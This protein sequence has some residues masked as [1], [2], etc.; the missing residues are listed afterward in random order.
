MATHDGVPTRTA[1]PLPGQPSTMTSFLPPPYPLR[2]LQPPLPSCHRRSTS[3]FP[4]L[5]PASSFPSMRAHLPRLSVPLSLDF[6]LYLSSPTPPPSLFPQTLRYPFIRL[7]PS[8]F[9]FLRLSSRARHSLEYMP[10]LPPLLNLNVGLW[11]YAG[12]IL[13]PATYTST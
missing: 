3:T 10:S 4:I 7:I 9:P 13:I 1:S 12:A 8:P 6:P 2:H 11:G 5:R